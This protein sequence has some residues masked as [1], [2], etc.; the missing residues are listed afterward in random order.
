M[1]KMSMAK[2]SCPAW[3]AWVTLIVGVLYLLS[4]WLP[5]AFSWWA[6]YFPVWGSLFTLVG[7]WGLAK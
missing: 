5:S 2:M 4:A 6:Q 7:L 3:L 1:A